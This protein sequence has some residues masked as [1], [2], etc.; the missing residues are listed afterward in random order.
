MFFGKRTIYIHTKGFNGRFMFSFVAYCFLE[1]E[2]IAK[3]IGQVNNFNRITYT[4]KSSVSDIGLNLYLISL[5]KMS[6]KMKKNR[7]LCVFWLN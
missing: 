4:V 7:V 1:S 5:Q 3:L 2:L 6:I